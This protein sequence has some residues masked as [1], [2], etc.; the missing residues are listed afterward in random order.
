MIHCTSNMPRL[1]LAA[2][3][4]LMLVLCVLRPIGAAEKSTDIT[5]LPSKFI[6][7]NIP[8]VESYVQGTSLN[9]E[10]TEASPP[11]AE[12]F[13]L[14][15]QFTIPAESDQQ[16]FNLV[17]QAGRGPGSINLSR[18]SWVVDNGEV[19]PAL[20]AHRVIYGIPYPD[21][22]VQPPIRLAKGEHLL[23]LRFYPRQ[24]MRVMNRA[25]EIFEKHHI[26]L[27]S[28][29]WQPAAPATGAHQPLSS[30]CRLRSHD[31]IILFGDSI[32]E[33]ATYGQQLE[34]IL[35]RVFPE[36]GITIYNAGVSLNR[37]IDGLAR[38]DEDVLAHAPDWT[39]LAFGVNDAMQMSPEDFARNSTEIVRRLQA[40][41][42]RVVCASPTGMMPN[43]ELL[44][45]AFG[46]LHASDRAT[47]MDRTMAENARLLG[48]VALDKKAIFADVYSAIAHSTI[49]RFTLMNNQ[50][51]P[52]EEGGR[53]YAVTLLRA[54]GMTENEIARSG[55]MRDLVYYRA[56]EVMTS[57]RTPARPP[58]KP[59][60]APLRGTVVFLTAFGD[61]QLLAYTPEGR[62]L[63]ILPTANH[64][65][66]M[67]YVS[68]WKELY[69]ACEGAGRLQIFSLP[70]LKPAGEVDLGWESYPTGLALSA[71]ETTLWIASYFGRIIEFDIATRK[72][73]GEI[74]MP[75][76][77]NGVTVTADG[78]TLLVACQGKLACVDLTIR[79]IVTTINTVKFT[80]QCR[81][82][83]DGKPVLLDVEHWQTFPIDLAAGKL[84]EPSPMPV[85]TRAMALNPTSGHLFASDWMNA[86]LLEFDGTR[87]IR[88]I[89]LPEPALAVAVVQVQGNK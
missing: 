8:K 64:P 37:T 15:Y 80:A 25:T 1:L 24:R 34:R 28:I 23:E 46:S 78:K 11:G 27:Q 35:T 12:Y 44:G 20:R 6:A 43:S 9:F 62:Q 42:T 50:W 65:A 31:V 45:D 22:H 32:T 85:Q 84:G 59:A 89:P 52:N 5:L 75:D 63:A 14:R 2:V 7:S 13:F 47:G 70:E 4:C 68:R 16:A 53:M 66:A 72:P 40:H 86:R 36:H 54:W 19:H 83:A 10:T 30:H 26:P 77:V 67:A 55:D 38:I 87:C 71:D 33:E 73:R 48:Q 79:K 17:F 3:C 29:R 57:A 21:E 88:T 18:F 39:V 41:G 82:S 49:P 76:V 74:G 56:L 81:Y 58:A 60:S 51:H 61:N 69:V